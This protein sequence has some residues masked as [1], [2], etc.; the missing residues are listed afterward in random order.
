MERVKITLWPPSYIERYQ[1]IPIREDRHLF[2]EDGVYFT[3]ET[4]LGAFPVCVMSHRGWPP[5]IHLTKTKWFKAHPELKAGNK[6]IIEVSE[7]KNKK[8]YFL[9]K[10]E[11]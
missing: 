9:R 4:N 5:H 3:L 7:H 1:I 6:L 2:P 11:D 10:L 8:E